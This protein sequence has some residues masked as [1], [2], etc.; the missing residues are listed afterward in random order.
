[1]LANQFLALQSKTYF[2]FPVLSLPHVSCRYKLPM[3]EGYQTALTT[4]P[5]LTNHMNDKASEALTG[6]CFPISNHRYPYHLLSSA[7]NSV[8]SCLSTVLSL[9]CLTHEEDVQSIETK[10]KLPRIGKQC[11]MAA[12]KDNRWLIFFLTRFAHHLPIHRGDF[13]GFE[14][15]EEPHK[16]GFSVWTLSFS[17]IGCFPCIVIGTFNLG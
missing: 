8:R 11:F 4:A 3:G 1:M 2:D 9:R 13:D 12:L 7:R 10:M 5:R 16:F 17:S 6:R 14:T 15:V